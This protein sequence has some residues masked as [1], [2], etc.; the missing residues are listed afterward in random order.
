[1]MS[2][3][4]RVAGARN[5]SIL[6]K[7]DC[8]TRPSRYSRLWPEMARGHQAGAIVA[9]FVIALALN[10]PVTA[11][12]AGGGLIGLTAHG[13][14]DVY[15]TGSRVSAFS[16]TRHLNARHLN[17]KPNRSSISAAEPPNRRFQ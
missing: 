7:G 13:A 12:S 17:T 11:A 15:L 14:Q 16:G 10:V 3:S 2:G 4:V 8:S 9:P 1:M 6:K 5:G